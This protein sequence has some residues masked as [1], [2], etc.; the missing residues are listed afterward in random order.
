M[1]KELTDAEVNDI[2]FDTMGMNVMD[3]CRYIYSMGVGQSYGNGYD[4][5]Y[6]DGQEGKKYGVDVINK[7]F[8]AGHRSAFENRHPPA[9]L[10]DFKKDN[11]IT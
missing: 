3:M 8:F 11:D 10:L 9:Y 7:A 2:L 4:A 1:K 6:E 5:G